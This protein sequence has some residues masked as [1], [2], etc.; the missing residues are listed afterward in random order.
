MTTSAMKGRLQDESFKRSMTMY[1]AILSVII[2]LATLGGLIFKGGS[3]MGATDLR[4]QSIERQQ[5]PQSENYRLFVTRD[6]W[7]SQNQA[8]ESQLNEIKASGLRTEAKIDKI[9]DILHSR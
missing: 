4:L 5:A 1:A 3:W 9:F 2:S 8:R 7:T 6:E